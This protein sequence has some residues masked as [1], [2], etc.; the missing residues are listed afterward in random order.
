VSPICTCPQGYEKDHRSN[1]CV[2]IDECRRP[3]ACGPGLT[4]QN[5]VGSFTC[6]KTCDS[7]YMLNAIIIQCQDINECARGTHRCAVGMRCENYPGSYR[8]IRE[9]PCGTGYSINAYTQDCEGISQFYTIFVSQYNNIYPI[10]FIY[11]IDIDECSLNIHDCPKGFDCI[12]IP[13]TFKYLL[14]FV[15]FNDP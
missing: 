15:M 12:N 3:N 14:I 8:C 10:F 13:G 6:T 2:D 11:W 9:K 4:C 7:G 5:T 1:L